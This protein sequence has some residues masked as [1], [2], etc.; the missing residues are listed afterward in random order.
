M[1]A[2]C[3]GLCANTEDSTTEKHPAGSFSV[4][5]HS[6]TLLGKWVMWAGGWYR[7]GA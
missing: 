1:L 3:A 6:E 2:L 4:T 7:S 5:T